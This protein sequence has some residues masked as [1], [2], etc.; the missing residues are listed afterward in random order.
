MVRV[1]R[2]EFGT[3]AT[4]YKYCTGTRYNEY[5]TRGNTNGA[6]Y[7]ALVLVITRR[8]NTLQVQKS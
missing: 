4:R 8:R 1:H 2:E 6:T 7:T 5:Q 3:E